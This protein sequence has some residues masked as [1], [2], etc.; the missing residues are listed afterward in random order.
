MGIFDWLRRHRSADQA[1]NGVDAALVREALERAVRL[2]PELRLA[3]G[4]ERRLANGARVS[5]H[6]VG[7]L[8][9]ALP[10][11]REASAQVW[12]TD[13]L[14]HAFFAGP[15]DVA[16]AM[17]RSTDLRRFFD[18]HPAADEAYA[19]LGMALDERR[20]LGAQQE[21]DAVRVDAVRTTVSFSDHQVRV[22]AATEPELRRE[23]VLRVL[24]QLTLEGL[25]RTA[26]STARRAA[27]EQEQALLKT[28]LKLLD[29]AGVGVS[30]VVGGAEPASLAELARLHAQI[31]EN[32]RDLAKLGLRSDALKL[33]L[34]QIGEVLDDPGT[35]IDVTVRPMRLDLMNVV[36]DD[37]ASTPAAQLELRVARV[38]A[39]PERVRAFSLVRFA[40]RD[41]L[42]A[43]R[44]ADHARGPLI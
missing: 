18:A 39:H 13:S 3:S 5:L 2:A 7:D 28:R 15:N 35:Y 44:I 1:T 26:V 27:L 25:A 6:H 42:P 20:T 22:C 8:V 37:A 21:G 31:E 36:V 12:S 4:Y 32:E 24:D 17:S 41:L 16:D 40:R 23:I 30:D 14:I 11:A 38:P 34:E 10:P 9:A 19:V 33:E 29:R 43:P